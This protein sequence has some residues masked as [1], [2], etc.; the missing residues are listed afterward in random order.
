MAFHPFDPLGR[1]VS[2]ENSLI[3]PCWQGI[4]VFGDGFAADCVIRHL[5]NMTKRKYTDR[6]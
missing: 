3:I 2:D 6:R 1:R 5:S 4:R